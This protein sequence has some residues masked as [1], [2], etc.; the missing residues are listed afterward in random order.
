LLDPATAVQLG[1]EHDADAVCARL[2]VMSTEFVQQTA[3]DYDTAER[4]VSLRA[5]LGVTGFGINQITLQPGQQGRI[6]RHQR[7]EEV[8]FV[9]RGR[10]TLVIEGEDEIELAEG[11]LA[12]VP[13]TV[14]RQLVNRFPAPCTLVAI[15]ASGE[16]QG[17]DGEAFVDWHE[18]EGH[19]PQEVPL[20]ADLPDIT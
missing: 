10:M 2:P 3:I 11:E 5:A 9:L 16:H 14:R 4:F 13:A 8:Y 12:R 6:H 19:P 15:G 20:P 1:A 17:R 18:S 7:Q